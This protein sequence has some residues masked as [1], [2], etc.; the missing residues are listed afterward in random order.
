MPATRSLLA[1]L[2]SSSLAWG[3]ELQTLSGKI[4]NG[5]LVSLSDK[6]I[7]FQPATGAR[8]TTPV[9]DVLQVQLQRDAGV[10]SGQKYTQLELV[11]GSVL[12]CSKYAFKGKDIEVTLAGSDIK[13]KVPLAAAASLLNDAHDPAVRQEWQDKIV[14]KRGNQDI[15]GIK[16]NDVLNNLEG[17]L[18]DSANA[19]GEIPFEYELAGQRRKRDLDPARAQGLLFLR[20]L[21]SDAPSPLCKVYDIYQG[22]YVAS[23]LTLSADAFSLT[24]VG[25]VSLVLP[26]KVLARLDYSNDKVVF[27]SDMK[28]AELVE[29]SKQGRKETLHMNK[30]LD[31]GSLQLGD[32]VYSKGLAIHAYTEVTYNLDGKYQKLDAV[33]GMDTLVGGD[34]K[35]VVTIEADGNKLFSEALTRKDKPRYLSYPVK[36]V[37]QL[38]IVVTSIGLFDFGDHVDLANA[39]LSK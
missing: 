6:E 33:L 38:R 9:G 27:L 14:A 24:T 22:T 21:S 17:T 13:L 23:K 36:G 10:P 26:K 32:T 34:G 2:L 15:V 18:G 25:G 28:P 39:K 1:L 29:K 5:E 11:D 37:K 35:P 8:V 12:L 7:V 3:G 31:N 20:T 19:K 30:N 4:L 16:L